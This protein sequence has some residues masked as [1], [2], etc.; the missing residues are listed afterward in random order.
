MKPLLSEGEIGVRLGISTTLAE[1]PDHLTK[2][3]AFLQEM[4]CDVHTH[5]FGKSAYHRPVIWK[6][7]DDGKQ[8]MHVF[9]KKS[10]QTKKKPSKLYYNTICC[11]FDFPNI[12]LY[13][14]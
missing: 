3:G 8:A 10:G 2:H 7:N 14:G 5:Y 11:F 12:E 4:F 9:T 13:M 6:K 1:L